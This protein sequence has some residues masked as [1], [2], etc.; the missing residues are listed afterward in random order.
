MQKLNFFLFVLVLM[1][2]L[3]YAITSKKIVEKEFSI[4]PTGE[5]EIM[6]NEGSVNIES[7]EQN[8]VK[9]VMTMRTWGNNEEEAERRLSEMRV[10]IDANSKK[11]IVK[12]KN[13]QKNNFNFFDI[14]DGEFWDEQRWRNS[15]VDFELTVPKNVS[16]K[17]LSDE[18]DIVV[19]QVD[20]KLNMR[21]NEGNI[22]VTD[23][24]SSDL[25]LVCDEGMIRLLNVQSQDESSKLHI[26]VDEG[27]VLLNECSILESVIG[28]DE[29]DIRVDG[30]SFKYLN[31]T[32]DEGNI[33]IE[34]FPTRDGKYGFKTDEGDIL[35]ALPANANIA[36]KIK[37]DEGRISSAFNLTYHRMEEGERLSGVIGRNESMLKV[38]VLEGDIE[39]KELEE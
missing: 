30:S 21:T 26:H 33:D 38:H 12:E 15:V 3:L 5:I 29:G 10:D 35:I 6:T 23:S 11:I 4:D 27:N 22:Y 8:E 17:V 24:Q 20:G 37:T 1:P 7:W 13:I 32:S 18:G 31:I 16:L 9:I 36:L 39:L 14:F 28:S 34:L 19:A 2:I 25:F